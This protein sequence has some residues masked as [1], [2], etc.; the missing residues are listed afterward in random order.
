MEE[1]YNIELK[2]NFTK[3]GRLRDDILSVFNDIETGKLTASPSNKPALDKLGK[4]VEE[5]VSLVNEIEDI[6]IYDDIPFAM[7]DIS[8]N[9]VKRP[10]TEEELD[11]MYEVWL[12]DAG[13]F[14]TV[15][16]MFIYEYALNTK[17]QSIARLYNNADRLKGNA[18]M[19]A[20]IV[21][22]VISNIIMKNIDTFTFNKSFLKRLVYST[23]P[24][25]T[26]KR[27]FDTLIS[28]FK[29]KGA[30]EIDK[31]KEIIRE[32]GIYESLSEATGGFYN[33]FDDIDPEDNNELSSS[34]RIEYEDLNIE[35]TN[36]L[37]ISRIKLWNPNTTNKVVYKNNRM[38]A[39]KYFCKD[40][41]IEESPIKIM[42][43][44]DLYSE[45]IRNNVFPIDEGKGIYALPLGYAI[46]YRNSKEAPQ[47]VGNIYYEF[48]E[49]NS[50]IKF[51]A[52]KN[53]K[54]GEELIIQA[55]E[56]DF[57]NEVKPNQFKYEQGPDP[58]YTTKNYRFI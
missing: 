24:G 48:D 45:N 52:L 2:Q 32:L 37:E 17:A 29:P 44:K 28:D 31:K 36:P 26:I 33:P 35:K 7:K 25:I 56:N 11:N 15:Y 4:K 22:F 51:Y 54:K 9:I 18:A 46:C 21:K 55:D 27:T 57:G 13:T 50:I 14:E 34:D 38:Y 20:D 12:E 19:T 39:G 53:I 23:V 43:S 16:E 42:T 41:V 8:G 6:H 58:I 40:D 47:G 10:F 3:I 30:Y 5:F 49:D 1:S